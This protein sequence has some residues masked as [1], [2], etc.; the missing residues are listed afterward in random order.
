[1]PKRFLIDTQ[2]FD[3]IVENAATMELV[4][5]LV[6][7]GKIEVIST[8]V[9][10]DE[11][12]NIADAARGERANRVPTTD[13]PTYGS[14]VDVSRLGMARLGPARSGSAKVRKAQRSGTSPNGKAAESGPSR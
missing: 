10:R 11:L 9:Q 6:D 8:H 3:R 12:A 13:V 4:Q 1:M 7:G 14:V 5:R 2:I